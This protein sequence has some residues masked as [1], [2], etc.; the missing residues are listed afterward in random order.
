M[1]NNTPT[2]ARIIKTEYRNYDLLARF[3]NGQY[4][5]RIWKNNVKVADYIGDNLDI[6]LENLTSIVDEL[7]KRNHEESKTKSAYENYFDA[8]TSIWRKLSPQ[9]M[10]VMHLLSQSPNHEAD[11][12]TLLNTGSFESVGECIESLEQLAVRFATETNSHYEDP[13][14]I[15][16]LNGNLQAC[17]NAG[18]PLALNPLVA[19]AFLDIETAKVRTG[20]D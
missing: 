3:W 4:R 5:G 10:Q 17:Q 9:Q 7:V 18:M 15:L 16:F 1:T 20:T 8:W 19:A 14:S 2:D 6:I 12:E 11:L 13:L